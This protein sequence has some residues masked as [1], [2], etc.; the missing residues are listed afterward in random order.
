M[1]I[2]VFMIGQSCLLGLESK[3]FIIFFLRPNVLEIPKYDFTV[4]KSDIQSN[5]II[6]YQNYSKIKFIVARFT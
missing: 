1:R 6:Y 5:P 4:C 2:R 3:K